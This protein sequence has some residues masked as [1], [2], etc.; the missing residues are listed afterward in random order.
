M[1]AILATAI[2]CVLACT[3]ADAHSA[4]HRHDL[5]PAA[6][7]GHGLIHMLQSMTRPRAWCGWYM[8]QVEH[9]ADPAFNRAA[10][11]A[12]Y[13]HRAAAPAPGVIVVWPHH[14]GVIRGGPDAAG[15]WLIE[16]GNDG[17]TVRTRFR[18]LAGA[19]A[20]RSGGDRQ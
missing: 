19:I 13:G 6:I 16:S 2:Y 9:V 18:S 7:L 10:E 11:W 5:S 15:D 14:V 3:A 1:R 4:R 8:R 20:L 12:H 17:G